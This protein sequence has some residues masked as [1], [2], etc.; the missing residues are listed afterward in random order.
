MHC[1][2]ALSLALAEGRDHYPKGMFAFR[3]ACHL[4]WQDWGAPRWCNSELPN[5]LPIGN[6]SRQGQYGSLTKRLSGAGLSQIASS[7]ATVPYL[8]VAD[9]FIHS[10]TSPLVHI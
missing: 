9:S 6:S 8:P 10:Y 1:S 7:V 4:G 3:R 5:P 2:S